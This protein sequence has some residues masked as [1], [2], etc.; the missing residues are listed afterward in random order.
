VDLFDLVIV[1]FEV[2]QLFLE[3]K[4]KDYQKIPV[5]VAFKILK[6]SIGLLHAKGI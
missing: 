5:G 2:N 6:F 3:K 1:F 4:L